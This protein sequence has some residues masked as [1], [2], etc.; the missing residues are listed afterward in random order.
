MKNTATLSPIPYA[1]VDVVDLVANIT[2]NHVCDSMGYVELTYPAQNIG[3]GAG[4]Y[5]IPHLVGYLSLRFGGVWA[6]TFETTGTYTV[7]LAPVSDPEPIP[8]PPPEGE[9]DEQPP[10]PMPSVNWESLIVVGLVAGL[11]VWGF[12]K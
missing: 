2:H 9:P 12:F 4:Y 8:S 3:G 6:V 10:T 11:M 1:Y 5:L 7:W